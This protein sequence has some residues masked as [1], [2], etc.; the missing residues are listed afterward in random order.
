MFHVS[1]NERLYKTFSEIHCR[2]HWMINKTIV[3]LTK[4]HILHYGRADEGRLDSG[5]GILR[6]GVSPSVSQ[7][8]HTI[9]RL[10]LTSFSHRT[11]GISPYTK[12]LKNDI[13]FCGSKQYNFS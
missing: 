1:E 9:F 8:P 13:Y 10:L 6:I 11:Y 7:E 3:F 4:K 2:I 12:W 5:F